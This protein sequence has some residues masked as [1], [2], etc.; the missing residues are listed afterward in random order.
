MMNRPRSTNN[1]LSAEA[2]PAPCSSIILPIV[3]TARQYPGCAWL[4]YYLAFHKDAASSGLTE[5]SKITWISTIFIWALLKPRPL[6]R[7]YKPRRR[8]ALWEIETRHH[9]P[10]IATRGMMVNVVGP[11]AGAVFT[12]PV[13][14]PKYTAP[15]SPTS[16]SPRVP[17]PQLGREVGANLPQK[18]SVH[19]IYYCLPIS[20]FGCSSRRCFVGSEDFSRSASHRRFVKLSCSAAS[21][22]VCFTV[23]SF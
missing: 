16:G 1:S 5:W 6:A 13:S 14:T 18:W 21:C 17:P 23:G 20:M 22:G 3:Q 2:F 11:W 4:A 8:Q 19:S 7:R 12:A 10:D 15:I 9:F